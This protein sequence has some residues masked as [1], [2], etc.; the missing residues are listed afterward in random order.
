[1]ISPDKQHNRTATRTLRLILLFIASAV[2]FS[3]QGQ[4]PSELL[5]EADTLFIQKKYTESYRLYQKIFYEHEQSSPDML[6]KM[7]F[8]NEGLGDYSMALYFLNL[9][10]LRTPEKA[11]LK[12]MEELAREHRLAGYEFNDFNILENIYYKYASQITL[13]VFTLSL[14]ILAAIY[15]QKRKKRKTPAALAGAYLLTLA[16]VFYLVNFDTPVHKG[17]IT[18]ETAY[19]MEDPSAASNLVEVVQQGH[20]V[21][22]VGEKD[23]WLKIKWNGENAFIRKNNVVTL[24]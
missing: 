18:S 8:I 5:A 12:K 3:L 22:I 10:Y 9:Y 11:V 6:V 14:L 13:G 1:M 16:I 20:R 4:E 2:S 17:I 21:R 19:L 7:A 15:R 23:I 24:F